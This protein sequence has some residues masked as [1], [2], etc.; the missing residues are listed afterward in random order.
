MGTFFED[1]ARSFRFAD[2][3]DVALVALFLYAF[4]TWVRQATSH[5]ASRRA[6]RVLL[7]V[8]GIYV[9]ARVFKLYLVEEVME[10]L[11]L[12]LLL[13]VVVVFQNDI[14]RI[15]DRIGTWSF[16]SKREAPVAASAAVIDTLTEAAAE[17]AEMKRGA[18]IVVRGREPWDRQVKGGIELNG[19]ASLPLLISIFNPTSP[20]HDGAVLLEEDRVVRF[21]AHLPL[22]KNLPEVSRFGGTRHAAALGMAEQT[23]AL[24]VVVSEERGAISVAEDGDLVPMNTALELKKRLESFWQRHHVH[25]HQVHQAWYERPQF[26]TALL[27]VSLAAMLWL[28]F[29]FDPDVVTRSTTAPIEFRNLPARWALEEGAPTEARVTLTGSERAFTDFNPDNLA[30]SL[31]VSRL[32]EGQNSFVIGEE[33]LDLPRGID[34]YSVEPTNLTLV[35]NRLDSLSVPVRAGQIGALPDSL[36]PVELRT[37]PAAV[38]LLVP[39]GTRVENVPTEPIDLSRITQTTTVRKKLVPPAGTRLAPGQPS[40]V[41]VTLEVRPRTGFQ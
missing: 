36:A 3:L 37:S 24:V 17:M 15:V 22:S 4:I 11:L 28:L 29:A 14:R 10:V 26:Q 2:L 6:L 39:G 38:V 16:G 40:E 23:D 32:E 12:V 41:D 34:L 13:S 9:L 8:T 35:A 1:L 25:A 27:S 31:D 5:G 21:G 7:M 33:N 19:G 20:G 18:L 30:I